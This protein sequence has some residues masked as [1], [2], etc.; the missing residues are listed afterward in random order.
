MDLSAVARACCCAGIAGGRE[1]RLALHRMPLALRA[2]PCP[3]RLKARNV[4]A[5]AVAE[6]IG[7]QV[8]E[9]LS[10]RVGFPVCLLV[11]PVQGLVLELGRPGAARIWA[12]LD[13]IDG[14]IKV[15]GLG[16]RKG[17]VRAAC[18][19]GWASA[20]AF[21][22]P[23][24][25]KFL[26][27][28]FAD[29]VAAAVVDG[30]PGQFQ[31]CPG[32]AVVWPDAGGNLITWD[33]TG[34]GAR[35]LYASSVRR[36]SQAMVFL[37][38]FQALDLATRRP[39]DAKLAVELYRRLVDRHRGGAY[40]VLR[41]FGTLS[42]LLRMMFGWR[43][44]PTW[45]EPQCA[46]FLVVNENLF[47]SIPAV[48]LLA[49]AGGYSMDFRG[50]PLDRRLLAA[51]RTS[52]LHAA[53]RVIARQLFPLVQ[54]AAR[55]ASPARYRRRRMPRPG[56]TARAAASRLL[57]PVVGSPFRDRAAGRRGRELRARR[58]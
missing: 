13:A 38:G 2:L 46:A 51:G 44:G 12:C 15:A 49:G 42:A 5:D 11:D 55:S 31:T 35:R 21:T 41:H 26:D 9:R 28:T 6:R 58:R 50:A 34:P 7:I 30:N 53:N 56:K 14:T 24:D 36:L 18:D 17:R 29:F 54:R 22:A 10:R 43:E 32:E 25:K 16:T 1:I 19:G 47:N 40:D 20:F 33:G 39:G 27:L 3:S 52:V 37:D 8:L 45:Y 48:P 57:R 23:T 4:R